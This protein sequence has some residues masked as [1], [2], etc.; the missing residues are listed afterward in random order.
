VSRRAAV[1]AVVGLLV[2]LGVAWIA[3]VD[4]WRHGDARPLAYRDESARL[5]GFETSHAFTRVFRQANPRRLSVLAA[6]GPRSS[7]AYRL[8]VVGV[9][10]ERDRVVVTLRERT[11]TLAHPGRAAL[12]YPYRLLVLPNHRKPVHV[13]IE[14][15]P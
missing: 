6:T 2:V 1:A 11:P 4:Y 10:E 8:D 7:T 5:R 3:Y 15:R 12:T 13:H 14:G 9:T